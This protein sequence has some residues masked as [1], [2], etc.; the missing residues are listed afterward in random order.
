[1]Y[2]FDLS[3]IWS[4]QYV[5]LFS[6]CVWLSKKLYTH[7]FYQDIFIYFI[8]LINSGLFIRLSFI[9]L[10]VLT[11]LVRIP[12]LRSSR[13]WFTLTLY[14]SA[15]PCI[16]S[17]VESPYRVVRALTFLIA[18]RGFIL[19]W[20]VRTW[21]Y[22]SASIYIEAYPA[23]QLFCPSGVVSEGIA[24]IFCSGDLR[25]IIL[26][27]IY[28]LNPYYLLMFFILLY[29]IIYILLLLSATWIRPF[30]YILI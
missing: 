22:H 11:L 12:Y 3:D 29:I 13:I 4:L 26:L 30:I 6:L 15:I 23:S 10:F 18:C 25:I 8:I 21:L 24:V 16:R 5:P 17:I 2:D 19:S 20:L 27:Y 28:I 1:M 9:Y 14:K 7:L